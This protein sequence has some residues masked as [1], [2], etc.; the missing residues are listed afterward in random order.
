MSPPRKTEV[1]TDG[2]RTGTGPAPSGAGSAPSGVGPVVSSAHLAET[3][4]PAL[5]EFEFGLILAG[6]AF[7]RWMTR[8]MSAAGV[9][10]LSALDV[11]VLHTVNHRGRPKK[12]ADICLVLSVE[13][14]H[15]VSYGVKKLE[16]AGLVASGRAGKEK[17]VEITERGR[18]VCLRYREIRD[19]LLTK[20]LSATT[21]DE[22]RLSE[23]AAMLRGLSG[24][25]DQATRAAASL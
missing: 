9:P 1:E 23:I 17:T 25:Y 7:Q 13:D 14:T 12:L 24:H 4:L 6:H 10:D 2:T 22:G 5:S 21:L 18:A 20:P 11:L 3:G 19:A 16:A 8:C 15:L